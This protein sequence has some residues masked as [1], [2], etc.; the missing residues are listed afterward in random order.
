[1]FKTN[2]KSFK[3]FFLNLKDVLSDLEKKEGFKKDQIISF[4]LEKI[5]NKY[6]NKIHLISKYHQ[7]KGLQSDYFDFIR[8]FKKKI[9]ESKLK[10]EEKK[11]Q[12]EKILDLEFLSMVL[13]EAIQKDKTFDTEVY[14]SDYVLKVIDEKYL[15]KFPKLTKALF[16]EQFNSIVFYLKKEILNG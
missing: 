11:K 3:N 16:E 15:N 2:I 14:S 6:F 1:M 13:R 4:Y 7:E 8:E 12:E 5:E 10:I 9:I